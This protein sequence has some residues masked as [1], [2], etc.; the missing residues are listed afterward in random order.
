MIV[1]ILSLFII[2]LSSTVSAGINIVPKEPKLHLVDP[3]PGLFD[4]ENTVIPSTKAK[5]GMTIK[6]VIKS[7]GPPKKWVQCLSTKCGYFLYDNVKVLFDD[8]GVVRCITLP[9]KLCY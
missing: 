2:L 7:E 8:E 5:I 6:E 4:D 9:N 3:P 1:Y